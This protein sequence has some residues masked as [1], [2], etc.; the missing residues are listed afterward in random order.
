MI[1]FGPPLYPDPADARRH[2]EQLG[3]MAR[4]F[5]NHTAFAARICRWSCAHRPLAAVLAQ[6]SRPDLAS[7]I[8]RDGVKHSWASYSETLARLVIDNAAADSLCNVTVPVVIVA[9]IDDPVCNHPFLREIARTHPNVDYQAWPGDHHL[10]MTDPTRAMA[11]II[12][13]A[14]GAQTSAGL[15]QGANS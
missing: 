9:G 5:T 13:I 11:L 8:A 15:H 10:P 14:R 1:S 6:L 3:L 7:R 2:I 12:D 4:L